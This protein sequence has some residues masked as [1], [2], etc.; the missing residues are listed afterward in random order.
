MTIPTDKADFGE[1]DLELPEP[2]QTNEG[3]GEGTE[4][5]EL[6]G[7]FDVDDPTAEE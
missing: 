1:T 7:P 3:D 4:V 5:V 2:P 6:T